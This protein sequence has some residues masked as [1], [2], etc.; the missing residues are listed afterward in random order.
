MPLSSR[1]F[2]HAGPSGLSARSGADADDRSAGQCVI[3][4]LGAVRRVRPAKANGFD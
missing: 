2:V 3:G 1:F 4:S